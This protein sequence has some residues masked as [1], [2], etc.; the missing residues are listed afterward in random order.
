MQTMKEITKMKDKD[1]VD[2]VEEKRE[3][4]RNTRFNASARD[5]RAVRT[6]KKEI[7]RALTELTTRK[8]LESKTDAK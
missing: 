2:L 7:A 1:L 6:A 4:V 5:V 8:K 3:S